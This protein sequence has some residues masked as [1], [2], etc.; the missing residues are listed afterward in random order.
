MKA[1]ATAL[2]AFASLVVASA[3]A[4]AADIANGYKIAKERCVR[5]HNIEP[6]GAFKQRPPAFQAIAIYRTPD[7]IWARILAPSPHSGMPE[8]QWEMTP[9]Q[10]QDVAAYV[11]S[12]DKPVTIQP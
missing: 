9:D 10:I 11:A 4:S 12:L 5:C 3:S 1:S 7:D 6:G 8:T 2:I